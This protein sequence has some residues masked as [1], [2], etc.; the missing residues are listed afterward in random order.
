MKRFELRYAPIYDTIARLDIDQE[1]R[2]EIA[3]GIIERFG[4]YR[5]VDEP[6]WFRKELQDFR[7]GLFRLLATDP[8]C[9]CAGF[10]D[11]PCPEGLE[12]R[13]GMHLSSA[14]D[15]RSAAWQSEKPVVRC[16][17]CGSKE[18]LIS[19]V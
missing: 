7:P 9:L 17:S 15:G 11:Q 12:I 19:H 16:V 13:V 3:E 5:G 18:F 6:S 4:A 1:T 10:G 14:P 8:L 2:E